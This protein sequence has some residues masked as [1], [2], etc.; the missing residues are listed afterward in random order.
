MKKETVVIVLG[1]SAL[2]ATLP[3]QKEAVR[4]AAGAVADIAASGADIVV[5]H[6][7][8][9]Q[10][11]MI[12]KALGEF[13]QNHPEYTAFPMSV[14][15][16]MSQGFIGY[17]LQNAIRSELLARGIRRTVSTVLT[18]VVVDPY[19]EAF[20]EPTKIIGRV[21]TAAEAE[22][23]K[24]KGNHVVP[25]EG[26]FR[27]IVASPNPKE[28]VELDAVRCLLR[29]GQIVIAC[30]GGGIPVIEEGNLLEGASAVIEKDMTARLLAIEIHADV[31]VMLTSEETVDLA[32]AGG[33]RESLRR[34]DV[35]QARSVISDARFIRE[36]LRRK[37]S[38]AADFVEF[39]ADR[40]A[41]ITSI[42]KAAAGFAGAA[43]TEIVSQRQDI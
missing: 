32:G 18:Q 34:I 23:E 30:G 7:N 2:G 4:K 15:S 21:L 1:S 8:S 14:C 9:R 5:T 13:A 40:R 31:L 26:G 28:I 42:P 12:H 24:R 38:C 16:A 22:E 33:R 35:R 11:G 41:V 37:M 19:D 17:D 10:I 25:A 20:Y 3:E 27:R 36:G 29:D 43:G 6:T 39:G